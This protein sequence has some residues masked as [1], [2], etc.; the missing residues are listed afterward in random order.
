MNPIIMLSQLW[1]A[2]NKQN[3]NNS[4]TENTTDQDLK[5]E[6]QSLKKNTKSWIKTIMRFCYN[7]G[8][9]FPNS[10][11]RQLCQEVLQYLSPGCSVVKIIELSMYVGT[12]H[13][14]KLN[15]KTLGVIAG[16]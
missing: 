16:I 4:N 10:G 6:N 15:M 2:N 14:N 12:V 1:N 8:L 11:K 5:W 13:S 9:N 3:N 7:P